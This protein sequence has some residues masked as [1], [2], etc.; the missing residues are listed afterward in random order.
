[1]A[2]TKIVPTT[3]PNTQ[4][5]NTTPSKTLIFDN[6]AHTI[7]AG[8]STP[9]NASQPSHCSL[10][11]N[12]IARSQRDRITYIGADLDQCGDFG[13]LQIRRPVEKGYIVNWEGEKAIWERTIFDKRSELLCNPRDVNLILTEAASAPTALQRN[14]DEIVFEEFEFASLWRTV[15]PG[16]NAFAAGA[17]GERGAHAGAAVETLL[18]VDAG[19]SHTTITPLFHG[20]PLQQA[21]RRL[22]LGGKLLTNH[23]K[24]QLSRTMD[25]HREEWICQEIKEDVCYVSADSGDFARSLERVW[26]GGQK[27]PRE[28]D[29][30]IV[31]DYVLPDYEQL[32]RGFARPHDPSKGAKMR[33]LGIGGASEMV[34]PV[35]NERFT[36]PEVVFTPSDIGMQQE[37]IAGT[38]MQSLAA[39]PEGLWQSFLANILVVGGTSKLPGFVERLEADLRSKIDD[40]YLVRVARAE[41]PLKN[42]WLG[43]AQIAQNEDLLKSLVVTKAEYFEHGDLWTRRRFAGKIARRNTFSLELPRSAQ[44]LYSPGETS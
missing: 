18:V 23:L 16:L 40:S 41:D 15:A 2:K 25:M 12:C 31:V 21:C 6:G 14:A 5:S 44:H 42:V 3:A 26:R 24:D 28:V 19:H 27:D 39:L 32:K 7:K 34:L 4:T 8:F 29:A 36:V 11:A 13:E 38:I 17:L 43:G 22:D 10:I 37:G 35:G 9:G 20:Q 33:R 30:S 1:M